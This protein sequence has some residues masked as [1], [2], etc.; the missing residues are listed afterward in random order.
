M[1][2]L[3][4]NVRWYASVQLLRGQAQDRG[5][6]TAGACGSAGCVVRDQKDTAEQDRMSAETQPA[7][8]LSYSPAG[9]PRGDSCVR[10]MVLGVPGALLGVHGPVLCTQPHGAHG[11]GG[12]RVGVQHADSVSWERVRRTCR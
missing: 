8:A 12:G 11:R 5:S 1:R 9:T 6:G 7:A 2:R 4:S 10:G 3:A